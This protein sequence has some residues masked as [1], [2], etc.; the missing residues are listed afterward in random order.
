[1]CAFERSEKG[2]NFSMEDNKT[3]QYTFFF[4]YS[5][6]ARRDDVTLVFFRLA[7]LCPLIRCCASNAHCCHAV[8]NGV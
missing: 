8:A 3:E 7:L 4:F 6:S 1:M 5:A 2:M